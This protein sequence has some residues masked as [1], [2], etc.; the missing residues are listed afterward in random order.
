M[1]TYTFPFTGTITGSGTDRETTRRNLTACLDNTLQHLDDT[2]AGADITTSPVTLH[3]LDPATLARLIFN[4]ADAVIR[5]AALSKAALYRIRDN[6]EQLLSAFGGNH[7]GSDKR[8]DTGQPDWWCAHHGEMGMDS[9]LEPWCHGC[10]EAGV[11]TA[12]AALYADGNDGA[13]D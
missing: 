7:P 6:A 12:P 13:Q 1:P 3:D 2:C 9:D 8:D 4:D 5:G 10:V 11:T